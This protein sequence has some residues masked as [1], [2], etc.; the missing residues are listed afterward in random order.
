MSFDLEVQ[1]LAALRR[2][3]WSIPKGISVL[4]GPNGIGKST[5]LGSI[6]MLG[7]ALQRS[8]PVAVEQMLGGAGVVR[9][10][11]APPEE[12]TFLQVGLGGG[13]VSWRIR[14]SLAG[15]GVSSRPEETVLYEG[16]TVLHR[17][18]GSTTCTIDG[19]E[20]PCG[21]QLAFRVLLET[22][23]AGESAS[24]NGALFSLAT[25]TRTYAVYRAYAFPLLDIA[26]RGSQHSSD[27]ALDATGQNVFTVLRNWSLKRETRPRFEFVIEALRDGFPGFEE[28]DFEQAGTTV[29]VAVHRAGAK[30][31]IA[32]ESTGFLVGLLHLVA[33]ASTAPGAMVAI[34]QME[35]SLH[36][37]AIR[38]LLGSMRS[39][40]ARH[41]LTIVLA[42]HSPVVLD[43]LRDE[44]SH[45]FV[46]QPGAATLPVAVDK[47][48]DP[49]WL[50]QFALGSLY[51]G[52]DFGAPKPP[53]AAA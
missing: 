26:R 28:L 14:L 16:R 5:L 48:F 27:A 50:A 51:T 42:T 24:R 46:M 33:V 15:A 45:V 10:I 35:D 30:L 32:Q 23:L 31:P 9:S 13:E 2:V 11:S 6:E 53:A 37:E 47:L 41:D 36:P 17:D 19:E 44:P 7:H 29:T 21:D 25:A 34:D 20:V 40:A 4:V 1:N 39:F 43:E 49:G 18:Q 8:L 52:S 22:H 3:V 12:D 38:R